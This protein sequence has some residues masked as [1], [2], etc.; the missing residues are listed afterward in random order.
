MAKRSHK[1]P[2]PT[3]G[4]GTREWSVA[5][6]Q[7]AMDKLH[8]LVREER[9]AAEEWRRA[10]KFYELRP[11]DESAI[12]YAKSWKRLREA[13]TALVAVAD[14]EPTMVSFM[15]TISLAE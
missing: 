9:I 14:T 6:S 12:A 8:R 10:G 5:R 15:H 1:K 7:E 4:T 2:Q 13:V 3:A 11:D